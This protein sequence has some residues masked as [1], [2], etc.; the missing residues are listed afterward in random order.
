MAARETPR[1]PCN[2]ATAAET[3]FPP[4]C[5]DLQ[6]CTGQGKHPLSTW[7]VRMIWYWEVHPQAQ[8]PARGVVS[9]VTARNAVLLALA[10]RDCSD[11]CRDSWV[12]CRDCRDSRYR[13]GAVMPSSVSAVPT[14]PTVNTAV[15]TVVT[16]VPTA[17]AS[18]S[19]TGCSPV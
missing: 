13:G 7:T 11:R 9:S 18:G 15:P 14:V 19:S 10:C 8:P 4:A 3:S 6:G 5:L 16:T 2:C 1:H 12:C 17:N